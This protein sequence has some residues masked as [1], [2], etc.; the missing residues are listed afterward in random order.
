MN[1][2]L[3]YPPLLPRACEP[4]ATNICFEEPLANRIQIFHE[5]VRISL[6]QPSFSSCKVEVFDVVQLVKSCFLLKLNDGIDVIMD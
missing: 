1:L 2:Q 3:S 4:T 5:G 6:F